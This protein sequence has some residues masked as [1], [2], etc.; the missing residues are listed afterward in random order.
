MKKLNACLGG[1]F[2]VLHEGHKKL[3]ETAF[4]L[5]DNIT[6]GLTTDEFASERKG[7]KVKPFHERIKQLENFLQSH[8]WSAKIVPLEDEAGPALRLDMNVLVVSEETREAA[9]RIN[10]KR[11]EMGLQPLIIVVIPMVVDKRGRKISSRFLS[12]IDEK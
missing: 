6:I 9:E 4:A 5:A 1:T 2:E 3:I 7:R 11:R 10:K 8:G 12:S